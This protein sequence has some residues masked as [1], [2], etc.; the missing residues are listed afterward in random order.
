MVIKT[1]EVTRAKWIKIRNII[2][3]VRYSRVTGVFPT[4][5]LDTE[6]TSFNTTFG[7]ISITKILE[8]ITQEELKGLIE[9]AIRHEYSNGNIIGTTVSSIVNSFCWEWAHSGNSMEVGVPPDAY[10]IDWDRVYT[11]LIRKGM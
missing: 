6:L 11:K 2:G 4:I 1:N 3:G 10:N 5:S 8:V 7:A 9:N